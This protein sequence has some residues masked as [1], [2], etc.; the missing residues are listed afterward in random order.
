LFL[1]QGQLLK[2]AF[3]ESHLLLLRFVVAV[4][5]YVAVLLL[6]FI[7]LNF[8]FNDLA[9]ENNISISKEKVKCDGLPFRSDSAN[10]A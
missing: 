6:H 7:Q 8:Q 10:H 5:D 1:N 9:V 2:I 3:Q 4:T